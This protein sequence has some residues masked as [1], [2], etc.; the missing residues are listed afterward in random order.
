M[1]R[2]ESFEER[3]A[4]FTWVECEN[5]VSVCL[6]ENHKYLQEEFGSAGFEGSGYDWE[7]LARVFLAEKRPDLIGLRGQR[8]GF[9]LIES[10]RTRLTGR[11]II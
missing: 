6:G 7:G 8:P 9:G 5:S 1:D 10:C 11:R 3:I 2:I 4:P